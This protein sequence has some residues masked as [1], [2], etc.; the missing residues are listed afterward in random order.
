MIVV[1]RAIVEV[2]WVAVK[3]DGRMRGFERGKCRRGSGKAN[4]AMACN[5]MKVIWFMLKR[6]EP[7]QSRNDGR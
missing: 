3:H 6:R 1:A 4:M 7:N 5:M 2:A